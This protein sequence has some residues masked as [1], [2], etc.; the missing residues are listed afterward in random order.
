MANAD[1]FAQSKKSSVS[2]LM[3]KVS[4]KFCLSLL[5]LAFSLPALRLAVCSYL[6]GQHYEHD[7]DEHED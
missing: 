2:V 3:K 7:E 1:L 6:V 4:G 5:P